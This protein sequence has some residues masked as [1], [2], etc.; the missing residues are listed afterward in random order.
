MVMQRDKPAIY[1]IERCSY[2]RKLY[3]HASNKSYVFYSFYLH[4]GFQ[5]AYGIYFEI[6]Q[7]GDANW[8][9]SV[10]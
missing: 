10:L 2:G 6:T 5:T 4:I 1:T 7:G 8:V 9:K 3:V